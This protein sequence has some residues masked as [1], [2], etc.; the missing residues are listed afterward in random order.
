MKLINNF[1]NQN[2]IDWIKR[3]MLIMVIDIIL[4][5]E[6]PVVQQMLP[7]KPH[8]FIDNFSLANK[9]SK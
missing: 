7:W 1:N 2:K 9:V 3:L 6:Q 5:H 8:P 4:S